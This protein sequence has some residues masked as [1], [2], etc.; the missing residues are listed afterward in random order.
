LRYFLMQA[1][2][3]MT[4]TVRKGRIDPAS[5]E[6]IWS[7]RSGTTLSQVVNKLLRFSNN[8][9]ANQIL[10]VMGAKI[11][12]PPATVDKGLQVLRGFYHDNLGIETGRIVEASG[13]SRQ[14]RISAQAML[15]I[16]QR[17]EPYHTLMRQEGREF[18]KTGHLEGVRTRA[19]FISGVDGQL[20]RFVVMCNTPGKS[21]DAIMAAL[22]RHLK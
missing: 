22:E 14:N 13:I 8:F 4:G 18:Y 21:T 11:L 17:Y 3:R 20:Y 16:L 12:G 19:G 2:I 6:L 1:G 5:D 15:K 10:L 9:I 7:Y